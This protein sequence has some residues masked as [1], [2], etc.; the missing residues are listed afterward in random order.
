M[1]RTL[2]K[3]VLYEKDDFRI[4]RSIRMCPVTTRH[5]LSSYFWSS[6]VVLCYHGLPFYI[7]PDVLKGVVDMNPPLAA[8]ES[9]KHHCNSQE[10]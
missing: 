10:L 4:I 6:V 1:K 3:P 9:I 7:H 8:L 2:W 5:Q